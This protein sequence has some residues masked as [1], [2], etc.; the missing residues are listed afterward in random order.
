MLMNKSIFNTLNGNSFSPSANTIRKSSLIDSIEVKE[1]TKLAEK[2]KWNDRFLKSYTGH[3]KKIN[4]DALI[5]SK[6]FTATYQ[7]KELGYTR[8]TDMTKSFS[9]FSGDKVSRIT[10]SYVK[11]PYKSQGVVTALRRYAVKH[12]NVKTMRIETYRFIN[13]RN[14]FESEGFYFAYSI[15]EEMCII[16]TRDFFEPLATYNKVMSARLQSA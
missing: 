9:E 12:E 3:A 8:V 10:E 6:I 4:S 11:P 14:Y 13:N 2:I 1:V 7:G 16:C 15:S 5:C